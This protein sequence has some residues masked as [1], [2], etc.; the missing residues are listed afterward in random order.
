MKVI[1][2]E[3]A[4]FCFGVNR[5]VEIL[6]RTV[7]E[8]NKVYT[9]GEI[10]HNSYVVEKY[11]SKGAIVTENLEEIE[12]S[13][14]VVIRSHGVG[15]EIFDILEQKNCKI[16]DATCPFVKKIH[17]VVEKYQKKSYNII[18]VGNKSHPE[19][20]GILGWCENSATV[21]SDEKDIENVKGMEN[22]CVVCQTTFNKS[23]YNKL[24]DLIRENTHNCVVVDTICDATSNRQAEV[25][26][27]SKRCDAIVVVGGKSSSNTKKLS[28]VA[29]LNCKNVYLIESKDELNLEGN[30][31]SCVG[32]SAG[33]S[34]PANIIKEVVDMLEKN[35]MNFEE[36]LE[37]TL[38]PLNNGDVVK[39]TVIKITPTEVYVNL[40][41]KADG[42]I[43]VD[44]VTIKP[45]VNVED[46]LSVGQE[47]EAFVVRV[48]DVDG[49]VT[50]SMSKLEAIE[51]R[52]QIDEAY[53]NKATIEGVV[54]DVVKG[55]IIVQA[56]GS[57]IFVPASQASDKRNVELESL[58]KKTVSLRLI[59]LDKRR[60]KI[61][62]SIRVLLTEEK[63]QK[64]EA[65]WASIEV[66]QEIK[67]VVKSVT[68]FGAFVDIGGVD[69]LVHVSELTWDRFKRPSELVK[70]GDI[71]DVKVLSFD[72]EARKIS[73]GHKKAED[74]P[75]KKLKETVNVDD[76]V[77]CK[78]VRLFP[79][80]AFAEIIPGVDGLIHISQIC[81]K[82][83][84]TP[85]DV[86]AVGDVVQAKVVE[87]SDENQRVGLSI[88]A[89]TEETEEAVE[90]TVEETVEEATE[91]VAEEATQEV[92]EPVVEETAETTEE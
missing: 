81:K 4:G 88:R 34:T 18:V 2:A 69:G 20:S 43:P 75:W 26:E 72:K 23:I 74:D 10:I 47:I 36:A 56:L 89:L 8:N 71:L 17:N 73:L 49:Y 35:E 38:K 53:E 40:D 30:H 39:G 19:V 22:V 59:D 48:N 12:N 14:I 46:V 6:D 60:N 13:S 28:E 45:N 42:I 85:A 62:G 55:G 86:L 7:A 91:T 79:F 68:D 67:G 66:G 24:I 61:V 3:T 50:L 1:L 52:K 32:V 54:T 63:K 70:P 31:F 5:A 25:A 87:I 11:R 57:R 15:K 37:N 65:L 21:V 84:A 92:V 29:A 80:G 41:A 58:L 16:V 51:A 9:L 76:V 44:Q 90:E 77:E 27:M 83:I 82:R 64:S 78:V 33:A